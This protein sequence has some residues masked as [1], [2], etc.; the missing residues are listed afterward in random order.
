[1]RISVWILWATSAESGSAFPAG[2]A[3]SAVWLAAAA[4]AL[5]DGAALSAFFCAEESL[6]AE[7]AAPAVIRNKTTKIAPN[8]ANGT[9]FQKIEL[10]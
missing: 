1:V 3:A 10:P 9:T 5:F 6:W 4:G 2:L 7:K 8:L